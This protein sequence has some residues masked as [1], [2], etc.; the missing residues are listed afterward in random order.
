MN[1]AMVLP[2]WF[3]VPPEGYGGIEVIVS[4]LTDGLIEKGHSVTL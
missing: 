3:K 4:L 1:I 2:P